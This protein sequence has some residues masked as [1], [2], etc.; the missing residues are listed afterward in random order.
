M[1]ASH[2]KDF[3]VM[4][5]NSLSSETVEKRASELEEMAIGI[6]DCLPYK[7][8]ICICKDEADVA[9]DRG[10]PRQLSLNTVLRK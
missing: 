10:T 5:A 2:L 4:L 7:H 9:V 8:L 6:R 1:S 3:R